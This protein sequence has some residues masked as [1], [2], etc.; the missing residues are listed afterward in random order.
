MTVGKKL[1]LPL[2][3][4]VLDQRADMIIRVIAPMLLVV[5]M[6]ASAAAAEDATWDV[7]QHNILGQNCA[8]CHSAGTRFATQ[9]GLLLTEDVAY[10]QLADRLPKNTSARADGLLRV[11]T[12]GGPA[13]VAQSFLWEKVNAPAQ[14]HF[15]ADHPA[16]GAI[17]PLG[18][19]ALTNGELEFVK[20]W[21]Y[22]GAPQT[23]S[24]VDI[25]VLDD[26]TRYVPREFAPLAPPERG[27]Q[28]HLGP[29]DVWP[30]DIND[31]EFL[32]F[33]PY[34][35]TEDLFVSRYEIS[36]RPGSHH[37]ILYNYPA[38][39]ATPEEGYR[40]VR[41]QAGVPDFQTLLE[42]NQLFPFQ[43]FVG[44][45]S[46]RI[47]YQ[48][49]EGVAL[50]L[51]A[52]SGFD[53]NSHSVNRTGT[54][55]TGEVYVNLHTVDEDEIEHVAD[56]ANFGNY[57]IALPPN[58]ETT[59]SKTFAFDETRHVIQIW[60][61]SHEHTDWFRIERVGGERDGEL[62]YWSNDWEHPS[63]LQ[64]ETPLTFEQGDQI[65][66]VTKYTNNTDETIRFG[67]LST[68]EMQFMFYIYYTG[69]ISPPGLPSDLT[70]NGFVDFQD[71][72][73]LLA[74]W[75]KEVT[76][77][78][79]NLVNADTT[80]VNFQDLTVLLADWT[81]SGP[82]GSPEAALGEAVPEPS[83]LLLALLAT[84]GLS[85]GWRRK[86]RAS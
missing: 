83:T 46:P 64:L 18:G 19:L 17:M 61:H 71:L 40:D 8:G 13:G 52:G 79:G 38:G 70:N 12:A 27:I 2:R 68:D 69:D 16:Y 42:L 35:T 7:I 3:F 41:N 49:P 31:R 86:R 54:T 73:I 59:L 78:E 1:G 80:P 84:L 72:T 48:L 4:L 33:E 60:S 24:V 47:D 51:P 20:R 6:A 28:F 75:N 56:Y 39:Q 53:L 23:G 30:S 81:G 45:Q 77:A 10:S 44:S 66:L 62:I 85:F 63:L 37:F 5:T 82:A 67:P 22:E 34:E 58:Q 21:I 50:R 26:T 32:Y 25:A 76:A 11:S 74:N 36:F 14:E 29:F 15:Y 65:R 57:D 43:F 55:Q 9:S